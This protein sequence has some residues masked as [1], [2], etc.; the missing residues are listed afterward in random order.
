M[1]SSYKISNDINYGDILSAITFSKSPSMIVEIGILDGFSLSQF[2]FSS[3]KKCD[4]LA[5]DIFDKFNGNHADYNSIVNKFKD[6]HNVKINYG[7][8]YELHNTFQNK[9]IDILHIDIANDKDVIKYTIEHY[10]DKLKD[11]GIII[12]EGG[13]IPRDNVDWMIKYNKPKMNPFLNELKQKY[14]IVTFGSI[15]SITILKK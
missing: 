12:F 6:Y 2:I 10:I 14:N 13:S 9:S 4:I 5:Y 11:D 1:R 3:S 7:D 15:P 8:F